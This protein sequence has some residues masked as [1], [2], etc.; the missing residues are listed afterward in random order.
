MVQITVNL[1]PPLTGV[2][3]TLHLVIGEQIYPIINLPL[4]ENGIIS[5]GIAVSSPDLDYA[6]IIPKQTID[7]VTYLE[8]MSTLFNLLSNVNIN[9]I[10]PPE[11]PP[12]PPTPPV[13]YGTIAIPAILGIIVML[14]VLRLQ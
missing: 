6:I 4:S 5:G 8:T 13:E 2:E 12:K 1:T 14:A 9:M 7:G 11:T 10:L 3:G